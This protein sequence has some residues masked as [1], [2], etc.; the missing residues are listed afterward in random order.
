MDTPN[1]TRGAQALDRQRHIGQLHWHS[2]AGAATDFTNA[3]VQAGQTFQ[4]DLGRLLMAVKRWAGCLSDFQESA[5]S[6]AQPV[7]LADG[8]GPVAHYVGSRFNH[9]LSAEGGVGYAA[10]TYVRQFEAIL[11]GLIQSAKDYDAVE[12]RNATTMTGQSGENGAP[13][14]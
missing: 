10:N 14:S 12:E 2:S 7:T 4:A 5:S 1:T 3:Q 6:L 8:S 13:R 11:E 9:R